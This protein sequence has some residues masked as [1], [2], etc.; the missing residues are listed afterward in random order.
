MNSRDGNSAQL[1][2]TPLESIPRQGNCDLLMHPLPLLSCESMFPHQRL[3]EKQRWVL[4]AC[5]HERDCNLDR[6]PCGRASTWCVCPLPAANPARD[7]A[8]RVQEYLLWYLFPC[9][10]L[11]LPATRESSSLFVS[12]A[13]EWR[14]SRVSNTLPKVPKEQNQA[15]DSISAHVVISLVC[16]FEPR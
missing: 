10:P 8:P 16:E 4:M 12:Q 1:L 6:R 15:S 13:R 3:I 5:R 2:K 7:G 9:S 14:L 11:N